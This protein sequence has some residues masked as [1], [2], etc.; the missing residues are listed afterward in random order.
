MTKP[1]Y[2]LCGISCGFGD[3]KSV[4]VVVSISP[5]EPIP[6]DQ[7][8]LTDGGYS[9]LQIDDWFNGIVALGEPYPAELIVAG[10][11]NPTS[12]SLTARQT[13]FDAYTIVNYNSGF[14]PN[15]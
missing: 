9:S 7:Y 5:V 15:T 14:N 2:I 3:K 11:D 13:L 1:A 12:A 10:N 4:R 6:L 8:D